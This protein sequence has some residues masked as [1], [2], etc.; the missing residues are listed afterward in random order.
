MKKIIKMSLS[1]IL[2]FLFIIIATSQ[3]IY[4]T[5]KKI[6]LSQ[7]GI[8]LETILPSECTE[9]NTLRSYLVLTS[10]EDIS[11]SLEIEDVSMEKK[12]KREYETYEWLKGKD[13]STTFEELPD[14]STSNGVFKVHRL[15]YDN[16]RNQTTSLTAIYKLNNRY[17]YV[18]TLRNNGD[19]PYETLQ[20]FSD[21]SLISAAQ[22]LNPMML[23]LIIIIALVGLYFIAVQLRDKY[24]GIRTTGHIVGFQ[25]YRKSI[26]VKISHRLP[27]GR[28]VIGEHV[29]ISISGLLYMKKTGQTIPIAYNKNSPEHVNIIADK[30]GYIVGLIFF[31]IAAVFSYLMIFHM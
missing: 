2:S 25:R 5:E 23:G 16:N 17:T 7:S 29:T 28:E 10:L 1:K 31:L 22:Q 11:V 18:I 21:F 6:I 3:S 14:I 30:S 8:Q 15:V 13:S 4:A 26:G 24:L 20:K 12:I 9:I 19:I 27:D